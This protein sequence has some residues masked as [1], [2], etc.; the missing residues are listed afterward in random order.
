MKERIT[1]RRFLKSTGGA[2]AI[3]SLGASSIHKLAS[4]AI[5]SGEGK[6]IQKRVLG[7]TGEE[8]SIIGFGGI[9]VCGTEQSEANKIVAEA[10]DRG[11]NY[12]DVA[13]SYCGG[14]AEE[15]LG[16]ALEPFRKDAFLACKTERRDKEGAQAELEQSLKKLRT[17]HFD[18]YQLH[19]MTTQED[20]QKA[21]GPGG[22]METFVKAKEKGMV[23]YLGFSAHSAEVAVALMDEFDFDS[24]LFP[25]NWVCTFNAGFGPQVIEKA[26]EKGVGR[27]ALK[28]MA[29]TVWGKDE[30]RDY[31]KCWYKPVTDPEEINLAL[32]F[33]LSQPVTAAVPPG[34]MRLFSKALDIAADF[35][36]LTDA[37]HD[38]LK[39]KATGLEPIFKLASA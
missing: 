20:F 23:R 36:P 35:Q 5:T 34:D 27:L 6:M 19:A 17:D 14:E 21:M 38:S 3:T 16:P 32:R 12:F 2:L 24:V 26:K 31:P 10:F 39:E 1:R 4:Q 25:I 37:E 13:P 9:V 7:E 15:R 18:L 11:I 8:L 22:A 33:T 28:A 29:K 30:E